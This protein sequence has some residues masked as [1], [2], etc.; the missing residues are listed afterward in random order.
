MFSNTRTNIIVA[1]TYQSD[2]ITD[3]AGQSVGMHSFWQLTQ[4]HHLEGNG[5]VFFYQPLHLTLN[6]FL[7]LTRGFVVNVEAHLAL[8]ALNMCIIRTL[9][10]KQAN[11][12]LVE[13]MLRSMCWRELFF[14]VIVELIVFH[15]TSY[16][17]PSTPYR[18]ERRHSYAPRRL[19]VTS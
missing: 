18:Y 5:Q 10:T 12:H 3:I 11:H 17:S 7:F 4:R 13:Q 2:A 9:T 8:L 6:L 1:N 19:D 15:L 14:V 16:T